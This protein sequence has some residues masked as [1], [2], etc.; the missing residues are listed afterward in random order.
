MKKHIDLNNKTILVTGGA[1]F[2]G[3]NLI[4]RLLKE[5]SSGTI[6]NIDNMNDYYDPKLKN[7]RLSLIEEAAKDASANYVFIKG[8]IADNNLLRNTFTNYKPSI[9]VNLAAQS[10]ISYSVDHPDIY[11][12]SNIIGFYGIL[13]SCRYSKMGER[14]GVEHLIY[15]ST[16]S[17]Y[18]GNADAPYRTDDKTETPASLYAATKKTDELLAYSYSKMYNIAATGL[19]IFP[20]Y[21]PV[22]RPDMSYYSDADTLTDNDAYIDDV[23]EG[24]YRVMQ[25]APEA[26]TGEDGKTVA[27]H[28]LYN[29]G[30]GDT[31]AL[32]EDYGAL[33]KTDLQTGIKN[34]TGWN[35]YNY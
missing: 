21:G 7:Y 28:A 14:G 25:G 15:A 4:L 33:P 2:I 29:I 26:E 1:G 12:E 22:G 23:I 34:T 11:L 24:I 35:K 17:V 20:V 5:L 18:D 13:Q 27:P 6:I 8:N 19:R 10:G 30:G 9:V 31:K 16:S 32:E 3:A